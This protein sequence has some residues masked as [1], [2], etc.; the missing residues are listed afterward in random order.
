MKKTAAWMFVMFT[1]AC[2]LC[3]AQAIKGNYDARNVSVANDSLMPALKQVKDRIVFESHR[4]G[5][6]EIM[7]MN[8]D[9]S[10]MKNLT[11]T[12]DINELFPQC[13][14]DGNMIAFEAC[15]NTT[16]ATYRV[17]IMNADGTGRRTIAEPARQMAWSP[18]GSK[19]AFSVQTGNRR[20]YAEN[21]DLSFY[22]MKSGKITR[23]ADGKTTV[24]FVALDGTEKKYPVK[25]VIHVLNPTWS[26]DGKWILC[27]YGSTMGISQTIV[28]IEVD[29]DRV[30]DFIHQGNEVS[31]KILGC[32][33]CV[34]PDGK[35]VT[36]AVAD[37]KKFA[38]IDMAPIDWAGAFPKC[39]LT[40]KID[41]VGDAAPIELY[42][43]DWSPD[44]RYVAF[45]RGPRGGFMKMALYAPGAVAKDWD[46]CIVDTKNPGVYTKLTNDGMSN[47]EPDWLKG[48][49]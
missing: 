32:R 23:W 6:F 13:S 17:E 14:P 30:V 11:N 40:K 36:W 47:K 4:N 43:A 24:T 21:K 41:L 48:S 10:G 38:W 9:G 45:S 7:V 22:D 35:M 26:K 46:I 42:H 18:D 3:Q 12:P 27:S 19:L 16:E 37:V 25:D 49:R 2:A 15:A 5:S 44:G 34:S 29:G 20:S 28:A 31:G 8:A 39:D 33:P 1:L